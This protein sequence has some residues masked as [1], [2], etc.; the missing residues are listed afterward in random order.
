MTCT[1]VN[2]DPAGRSIQNPNPH[3]FG[4]LLY[5]TVAPREGKVRRHYYLVFSNPKI[6]WTCN[7]FLTKTKHFDCHSPDR[8]LLVHEDKSYP[9]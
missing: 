5:G 4:Y 1:Y 9:T 2:Y 6:S 3:L 8:Q 7:S